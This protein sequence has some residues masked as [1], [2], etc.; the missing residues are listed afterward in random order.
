[1]MGIGVYGD[2]QVGVMAFGEVGPVI[3]FD[4]SVGGT[5]QGHPA[6]ALAEQIGQ[7]KG[8]LQGDGFFGEGGESAGPGITAAVTGI[9]D[10]RHRADPD[11]GR[12]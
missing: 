6:A 2:E 5:G 4:I 7:F 12:G 3:Q 8:N 10:D 9:D 11:R 1:M